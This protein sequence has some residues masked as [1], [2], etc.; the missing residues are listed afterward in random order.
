MKKQ[1]KFFNVLEQYFKMP[2][3]IFLKMFIS[4]FYAKC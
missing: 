3:Q 1:N 2:F 4:I